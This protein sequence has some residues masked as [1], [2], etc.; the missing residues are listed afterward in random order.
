MAQVTPR[1]NRLTP[2]YIGI[3]IIL[4]AVVF[5]GYRMWATACPAPTVIEIGVL[6]VI[7][8]VYLALMYLTLVSQR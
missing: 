7:P 4:A 6:T 1:N 2:W 3:I 8:I 5:I